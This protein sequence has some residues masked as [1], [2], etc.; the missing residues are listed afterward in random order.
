MANYKVIY[1]F[2]SELLQCPEGSVAVASRPILSNSAIQIGNRELTVYDPMSTQ[3]SAS[4][5]SVGFHQL[6]LGGVHS[7][8]S[9]GSFVEEEQKRS[10]DNYASHHAA[11]A[12]R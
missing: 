8:R 3:L 12:Q 6:R 5:S 2:F 11:A 9:R 7:S 4:S 1:N 10:N